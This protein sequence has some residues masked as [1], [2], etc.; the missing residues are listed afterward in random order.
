MMMK[1]LLLL[2][3]AAASPAA[4]YQAVGTADDQDGK[5]LYRPPARRVLL[6]TR[7]RSGSTSFVMLLDQHPKVQDM[8]EGMSFSHNEPNLAAL[9]I[10]PA[11]VRRDPTDAVQRVLASCDAPT[12]V[13]NMHPEHFPS[14][15][16]DA[17]AVAR[18]LLD[19]APYGSVHVVALERKVEDAFEAWKRAMTS[20][21]WD[22]TPMLQAAH[23][24]SSVPPGFTNPELVK[25]TS[26]AEYKRVHDEWY[27]GVAALRAHAPLLWLKSEDFFR[28]PEEEMRRVVDFLGL[29][30]ADISLKTFEQSALK[31]KGYL[32]APRSVAAPLVAPPPPPFPPLGPGVTIGVKHTSGFADRQQ[33]LCR[34]LAS[35]R[36][37]YSAE[38]FPIIVAYDGKE[39]YE[40]GREPCTGAD[41][42]FLHLG[43]RGGLSA[44]RN[45]IVRHAETEFVMIVDDDVEFIETTSVE[46]LI[47]HLRA[48]P[49]L[50]LAAACYEGEPDGSWSRTLSNPCNAF[51]LTY[52][53]STVT[54]SAPPAAELEGA[55]L[56]RS[57]LVHN[58]FVARTAELR[59]LPWDERQVMMEHETF[60]V[61]VQ[62][63]GW[64]VGYDL[65]VRVR[66]HYARSEEYTR[67]SQRLKTTQYLQ[68][69]CRNFPRLRKWDMPF[70]S[71]DCDAH[72]MTSNTKGQTSSLEW[73]ATDDAS[74]AGYRPPKVSMF[75]AVL[76]A[77]GH[78][79]HRDALRN[80]WLRSSAQR[81]AAGSTW[82]YGFFVRAGQCAPGHCLKMSQQPMRGDVVTLQVDDTYDRLSSKVLRMLQWVTE[83]VDCNVI[84]KVDEDTWVDA[85]ATAQALKHVTAASAFYGGNLA[86]NYPVW[87]EGK[88]KVSRKD[89]PSVN[90]SDYALGGAYALSRSTAQQAVM[91]LDAGHTPMIAN[92]EDV[93]ISLAVR[94]AGVAPAAIDG[95]RGSDQPRTSTRG[96]H[97]C[98]AEGV[99]AYH[100][101]AGG[102]HICDD[103]YRRRHGLP[104]QRS[105]RARDFREAAAKAASLPSGAQ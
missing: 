96:H 104:V 35:I 36:E 14:P 83:T 13:I 85:P 33:K 94:A 54:A 18:R 61:K 9:G 39:T 81:Q 15:N 102:M 71:L 78:T 31:R 28:A 101:P 79:T 68:Y 76:S 62:R 21:V 48:D 60:F 19:G 44:G 23:R 41:T 84:L 92:V 97:S 49:A 66:H 86:H 90:H 88:W 42:T 98:C 34:L 63:A 69:L 5:T 6:M 77:R 67:N 103:C 58:A 89:V 64:A 38:G 7:Q 1:S 105:A 40:A 27:E 45:A 25:K 51:N 91:T 4:A 93:T 8:G 73:S 2:T 17:G 82:D 74:T 32:A 12:C 46:T 37:A 59:K 70:W 53:G 57:H 24:N 56:H 16:N 20:G 3:L 80:T 50:L 29:E 26:F 10:T 99:L 52:T 30:R 75:V 43:A 11:D 47:G 22:A 100:K 72:T 87:R 95:F 55:G 65:S